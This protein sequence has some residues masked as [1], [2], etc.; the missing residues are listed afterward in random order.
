MAARFAYA[1]AFNAGRAAPGLRRPGFQAKCCLRMLVL[2]RDH[3]NQ[4]FAEPFQPIKLWMTTAG[5]NTRKSQCHQ[6]R[7]H[8][9]NGVLL[10]GTS[11][12]ASLVIL[13][14]MIANY[15]TWMVLHRVWFAP[16]ALIRRLV[17]AAVP[18]SRPTNAWRGAGRRQPPEGSPLALLRERRWHGT[19]CHPTTAAAPGGFP[20]R[21]PRAHRHTGINGHTAGWPLRCTFQRPTQL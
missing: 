18:C 16:S 1:A 11:D 20:P 7:W 8:H 12:S 3:S 10:C 6:V 4:P 21:M 13:I 5:P 19:V 14:C 9:I 17:S 2:R 15:L